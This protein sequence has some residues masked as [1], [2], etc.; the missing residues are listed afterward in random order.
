MMLF[1]WALIQSDTWCPY[2]KNRP[3]EDTQRRWPPASQ[4]EKPQKKPN[5]LTLCPWISSLQNC[6]K[7]SFRHLRYSMSHSPHVAMTAQAGEDTNLE[8]Q[9]EIEWSR[10]SVLSLL[11]EH[12]I[13]RYSLL[14]TNSNYS[15]CKSVL[16]FLCFLMFHCLL[17]EFQIEFK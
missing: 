17:L 15:S 3:C 7:I 13:A 5:L 4:G 11:A 9:R 10:L 6:H 14:S 16:C 8:E 1:R 12:P 2:K